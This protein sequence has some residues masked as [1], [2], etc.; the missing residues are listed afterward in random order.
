MCGTAERALPGRCSLV[1][2]RHLQ[3]RHIAL[4]HGHGAPPRPGNVFC[5]CQ[6]APSGR[7]CQRAHVPPIVDCQPQV[8]NQD[9]PHQKPAEGRRCQAHDPTPLASS[10]P[11]PRASIPATPRP[12]PLTA[13]VTSPRRQP[14]IKV[15]V[16]RRTQ[17]CRG[18]PWPSCLVSMCWTSLATSSL[19]SPQ[20]SRPRRGF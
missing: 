6:C 2:L 9:Q 15:R 20:N 4:G 13:E 11:A 12:S 7:V 14:G 3:W 16:N 1:S 17:A 10:P 8:P 18:T 19:S 5:A